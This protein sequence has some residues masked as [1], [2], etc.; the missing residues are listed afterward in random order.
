IRVVLAKSSGAYCGL[1][2]V[3]WHRALSGDHNPLLIVDSPATKSFIAILL[4]LCLLVRSFWP[5][6]MSSILSVLKTKLREYMLA[7]PN[8]AAEDKDYEA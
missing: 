7:L 6:N 2:R 4:P 3:Q 1:C 5:S 8:S